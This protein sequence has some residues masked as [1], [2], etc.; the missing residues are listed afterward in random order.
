MTLS[1]RNLDAALGA[2]IAG[3]DVSRPLPQSDIDAIESAWR[4]RLV[5]VMHGKI[6]RT[7]N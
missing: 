1:I 7:R 6:F 5:V 2:E 4:D 3:V